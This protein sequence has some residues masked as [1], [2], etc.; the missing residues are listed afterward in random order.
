MLE[1]RD[2]TLQIDTTVELKD[3]FQAA[4]D[5]AKTKLIIAC[6]IVAAMIAGFM[7]FFILIGEQKILWQAR[8]FSS[9]CQS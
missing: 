4:F 5:S 6:L 3:Y 1:T 7:Y 9:G 2:R 8:H